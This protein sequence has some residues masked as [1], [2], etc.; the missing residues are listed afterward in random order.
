M[1]ILIIIM[2][3]TFQLFCDVVDNISILIIIMARVF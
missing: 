2:A 1:F 3:R